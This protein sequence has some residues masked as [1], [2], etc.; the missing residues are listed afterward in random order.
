MTLATDPPVSE[1]Q[2]RAMFAAAAGHSTLGIP[3]EVGEE[4]VGKAK[5][6]APGKWAML[7]RLFSE[8]LTEEEQEP[9]H[10]ED[11][12]RLRAAGVAFVTPAGD[13]LFLRR[14]GASDHEGEW[15]LP[16]GTAEEDE[17]PEDTARREA[18]EETGYKFDGDGA[19]AGGLKQAHRGTNDEGVDFTTFYQ[20]VAD[21][22][23]PTLNDESTDYIWAPVTEPPEPLHPGVSTTLDTLLRGAE[24]DNAA[25]A[26]APNSGLPAV[27]R[28]PTEDAAA[29]PT[30]KLSATTRE[31]IDSTKHREDMPESAFLLPGRRKYPIKER[32]D[33]EWKYTRDLLLA[34]ARRARLEGRGDLARRA[35][36]IRA[37]EFPGAGDAET[38]HDPK[39]G[40][41]IASSA[42]TKEEHGKAS[43]Y[44]N[45][46]ASKFPHGSKERKS[47]LRA[48]SLHDKASGSGAGTLIYGQEARNASKKLGEDATQIHERTVPPRWDRVTMRGA[49][50]TGP[51]ADRMSRA[52]RTSRGMSLTGDMA[53][54]RAL[55]RA[56]ASSRSYDED[57][58]L[59]VDEANIS[60][61]VVNPYWGREINAVMEGKP[62]WHPLE[63]DRKYWLLR[64]PEELAKAA[65]TFNHLPILSEHVPVSAD[66]H[67]P[68]LVIGATGTDAEFRAPY[69][70]NS[71]V[72]WPRSAINKIEDGD[73]RQL[74][75]AY[76]YEADMTPGTY[77]GRRY[78]GVMRNIVGNHVALVK[79][80][81]AGT[82]VAVGDA[83]LVLGHHYYRWP[84]P[85]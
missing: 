59:H 29:D 70:T 33:G 26:T 32:R 48:S 55:D 17:T 65:G 35:D 74:S 60:K 18:V 43:I 5:D 11:V 24:D 9:E 73:E 42:S 72:F 10:G 69:L 44:H 28:R 8:W 34:A 79:D 4:F 64:D 76:K 63:P 23:E 66:A 13:C 51:E 39:T 71:L 50:G 78:D 47:H 12:A 22:F 85:S 58:R 27:A 53:L 80:G 37:R 2:R 61:A 77:E 83:A 45:L 20:P 25:L 15:G 14:S 67:K 82:D 38:A 7:K 62:G 75:C 56:G 41:F 1:A 81:R 21:R 31:E 16:G 57:G 52:A 84:S 46:Q 54:D 30:G 3:K 49:V 40:Q 19:E 68:E 36:A 6:M